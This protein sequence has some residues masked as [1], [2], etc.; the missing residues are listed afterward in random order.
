MR[1]ASSVS[2]QQQQSNLF[3]RSNMIPWVEGKYWQRS[4]QRTGEIMMK[5]ITEKEVKVTVGREEYKMNKVGQ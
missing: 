2:H 4:E 5:G 3:C 1:S